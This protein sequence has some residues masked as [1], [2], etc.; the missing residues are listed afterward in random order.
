MFTVI[1]AP[2]TD[3]VLMSSNVDED[4]YPEYNELTAYTTSDRVM[5]AAEHKVYEAVGDTTGNNPST[6]DGTYWLLVGNTNRWKPF[7]R[8][9]SE[10]AERQGSITYSFTPNNIVTAIALFGLEAATVTVEVFNSDRSERIEL[11]EYLIVHGDVNTWHSWVHS[12]RTFK[13]DVLFSQIPSPIGGH[14]DV[15]IDAG[16]DVARVGRIYMGHSVALGDSSMGT[17]P[18]RR[19]YSSVERDTFGETTIIERATSKRVRFE[20]ALPTRTIDRVLG[21]IDRQTATEAVYYAFDDSQALGTVIFGL[22]SGAMDI[23]ITGTEISTA[24][25]TIEGTI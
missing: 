24:E 3:E 18:G 8:K 25:L 5:V 2:V 23:P 4:D 15:T 20:F 14:I 9:I 21:L 11:S 22:P 1:R 16:T 10:K 7:N 13:E 17:S 19:N 12:T 6:D